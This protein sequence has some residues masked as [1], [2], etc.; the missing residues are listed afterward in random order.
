MFTAQSCGEVWSSERL[1]GV[2]AITL[3]LYGFEAAECVDSVKT[4]TSLSKGTK[5]M[6]IGCDVI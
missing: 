3:E 5:C 6:V 2:R 1:R 4:S